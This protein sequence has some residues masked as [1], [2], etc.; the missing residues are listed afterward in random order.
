[1][2]KVILI[3]FFLSLIFSCEKQV[4]DFCD[5]ED[6]NTYLKVWKELIISRNHLTVSYYNDHIFPYKTETDSW[7]DGK[8]FRV[9]YKVKIDWAEANLNDQFIIWLDPSTAGLYPSIP[10][11][12]STNLSEGQIN[13]LLND[14]A[15]SSSIH[16]VAKIDHLKYDSRDEAIGVLQAASGVND[17]GKGEVSY[18]N[19]SFNI[20]LGHPFLKVSA[21]INSSE[22]KCLTGKIDLVTGETEV[23]NPPCVIYFCFEKGTRI[24]LS[25]GKSLP[26]EKLQINDK[27]LS[28]DIET[29]SIG[30][31]IVQKIDSVIHKNIVQITFSDSTINYNTS[32]HPYFVKGKGWCSFKPSETQG[33]YN[34]KTKQLQPGDICFKTVNNKLVEVKVKTI[35]EKSDEI[36]TYNVSGLKKNKSYFANGMLVSTEEK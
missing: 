16:K 19:P 1:M 36:M 10:A 29:W 35:T 9:E 28:V 7:N 26:I 21:T 20:D 34:I 6:C 14:F 12:R 18:E 5:S 23:R 31:D 15:F 2:R 24:A 4:T 13:I 32:D 3:V 30:E 22:N 27:I 25:N 8:S 11:P 33:N 17:L